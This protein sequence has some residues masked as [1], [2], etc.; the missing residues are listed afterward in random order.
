MVEGARLERVYRGNSIVG[1][2]PTF[3]AI[4]VLDGELAVPCNLQSAIE[5]LNSSQ[6]LLIC[7]VCPMQVVL[8]A[9]S[10]ATYDCEP[11][12]VR[13]KAAISSPCV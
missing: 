3:S 5:G 13:K 4:A 12:Q 8:M 11:R 7:L 10:H 1:S 6:R 9:G 2:N